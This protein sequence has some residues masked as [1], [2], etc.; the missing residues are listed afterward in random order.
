MLEFTNYSV[1]EKPSL[2]DFKSGT[3]KF[4]SVYK[5]IAKKRRIK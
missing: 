4:A 3:N 1:T 5:L 2:E